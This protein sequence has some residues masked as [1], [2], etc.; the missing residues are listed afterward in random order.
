MAF[1]TA[2]MLDKGTSIRER[3]ASMTFSTAILFDM[4]T[5][6]F[7]DSAST[8]F[9]IDSIIFPTDSRVFSTASMTFLTAS[10]TSAT[11]TQTHPP[12]TDGHLSSILF[13]QIAYSS[14]FAPGRG[15]FPT[16]IGLFNHRFCPSSCY[17]RLRL[18]LPCLVPAR[19]ERPDI[20]LLGHLT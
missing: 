12:G 6:L 10:L 1:S 5:S 9:P 16:P 2:S 7:H 19:N 15:L 17:Y 14:Y 8:V 13:F 20:S 18:F 4:S 11:S 3:S